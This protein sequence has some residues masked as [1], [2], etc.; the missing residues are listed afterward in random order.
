MSCDHPSWRR[1]A[2]LA[3][4]LAGFTP[5]RLGA[6]DVSVSPLQWADPV[7][8]PDDL[9]ARKSTLATRYPEEL[10]QSPDL[11]YTCYEVVTDASGKV[12]MH[13]PHPTLAAWQR[14][15]REGQQRWEFAPARR[16]GKPVNAAFSFAVL[17]NP[18]SAAPGA[19]NATPRLLEVCLVELP[20]PQGARPTDSFEDE[21]ITGEVQVDEQ[22]LVTRVAG[23]APEV[24]RP[25]E[26]AV[27]NWRFAPAR[28]DGRPVAATVRVPFVLVT[29]SRRPEGT[30]TQPR[31]K[32]QVPPIYPFAMRLSRMRGEV[33]V[34][35]L[36]DLEGRVRN[37]YVVR[38]LNPAFDEP[39]LEAVRR[40]RFEPGR[41]GA[42][43]VTTHMQVPIVFQLDELA[44][45]GHD[46]IEVNRKP[47]LSKLPE[48]LRYDTPP[49]VT[50]TVR[51]VY[52]FSA[53]AAGRQGKATVT[54]LLN[55]KGRV[56][57]TKILSADAP[58]FGAALLAAIEQFTYEP[59]LK[60]G[61][62]GK[63]LMSF[64]QEFSRDEGWQLV[65]DRDLSLL[66]REQKK[67]ASIVTLR[68]LDAPLQPRSQRPPKFPLSQI[69]KTTHGEAVIE[70]I[71]DEEGRA[72]LPRVI[73]ASAEAFGYAAVQ[74]VASW[75]FEP[76]MRGRRAVAVRVQVPVVFD[77]SR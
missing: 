34:D 24:Q 66:R 16:D 6:Q 12:L 17:F 25:I 59:A 20:R 47:D 28:Q 44:G 49:R 19:P 65:S 26:I 43:P 41:I 45:G 60:G 74:G 54:Y 70:F 48:E 77:G 9:P 52:P 35:F 36:V 32:E 56:I 3:L 62:P 39:A 73:S 15:E 64:R 71:V 30:P 53:L 61:R 51:P 18:A 40:W 76:P 1:T 58:E 8:A 13:N 22:G 21:V 68:E 23:V 14:A 29:G 11:G 7:D 72:R 55:E 38:S 33:V 31:V 37:A 63:A 50:G 67:P 42:R 46:G 27:K 2:A 5:P 10:R 4:L 75:Q 69:G 57:D